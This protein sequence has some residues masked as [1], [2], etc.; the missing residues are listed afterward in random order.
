L[1]LKYKC[2]QLIWCY[3]ENFNN[4][5]TLNCDYSLRTPTKQ[6]FSSYFEMCWYCITFIQKWTSLLGKWTHW[7]YLNLYPHATLP[8]SMKGSFHYENNRK[9]NT[10]IKMANPRL[11]R[12]WD[13]Q[14]PHIS[15]QKGIVSHVI[16]EILCNMRKLAH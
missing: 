16:C 8:I 5:Y 4:S 15:Q 13:E 7:Q 11:E 10:Y 1:S 14:Y 3:F 12:L 6:I 9:D 2:L